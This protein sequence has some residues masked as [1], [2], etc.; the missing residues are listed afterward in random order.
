MVVLGACYGVALWAVGTGVAVAFW[1]LANTVWILPI[2]ELSVS[3]LVGHVL[4]G[5]VL[6]VAYGV[7]RN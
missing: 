2:P 5:A 1:A 7:L 3:S 6:G 4:Y